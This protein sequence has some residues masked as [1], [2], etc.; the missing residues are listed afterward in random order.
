M[1]FPVNPKMG[2]VKK[3]LPDPAPSKFSKT[4]PASPPP[5]GVR[6]APRP[7]SGSVRLPDP[8]GGGGLINPSKPVGAVPT[9]PPKKGK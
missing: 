3:Y 8:R 2:G 9:Y 4:R 1:P 5:V 7:P 6:P